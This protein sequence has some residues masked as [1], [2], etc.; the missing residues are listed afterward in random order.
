MKQ[1]TEKQ[2]N[3]INKLLEEKAFDYEYAASANVRFNSFTCDY[4]SVLP[5]YINDYSELTSYQASFLIDLLFKAPTK[6]VAQARANR[7]EEAFARHARLV[8]YAK[9][10]GV[11]VTTRTKT[12]TIISKLVDAGI[13]IPAEYQNTFAK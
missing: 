10:N 3:L 12:R 6:E 4:E 9:S 7:K 11:R 1:A 5:L 8:D 2:I 13:E